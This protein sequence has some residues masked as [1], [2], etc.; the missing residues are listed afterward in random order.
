MSGA[1]GAHHN[2]ATSS[3]RRPMT[4][5]EREEYRRRGV[6]EHL[7]ELSDDDQAWLMAFAS[8]AKNSDRTT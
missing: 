7:I 6:P 3:E 5:S 1:M 8:G 2:A 4:D